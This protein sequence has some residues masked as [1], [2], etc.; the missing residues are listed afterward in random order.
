LIILKN[1]KQINRFN[2]KEGVIMENIWK[3]HKDYICE[4]GKRMYERQYV[5]ANDG[6]ISVKLNENMILITP[7]GVSKG[8]MNPEML[9]KVD[10][11]GNI[12]EG[13]LK[14]SSEIKMHLRV[15]REK[16]EIKAVVHAHPPYAT[17]FAV[18]GQPLDKKILP[19]AI[20]SLGTVPVAEYGTPSTEEIPEAVVEFLD[21]YNA[22]LLENHGVLTWGDNLKE[23]YFKMETVE[24]YAQVM[25]LTRELEGAKIISQEQV[26]KLMELRAKL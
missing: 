1:N 9:V 15:Y 22:V 23:A 20:I 2:N 6:N 19:E 13:E 14:P 26:N 8:F 10:L 12:L 21:N 25:M 4:I 3:D 24:F 16:P 5:A 18:A 7:T 17:S 11:K